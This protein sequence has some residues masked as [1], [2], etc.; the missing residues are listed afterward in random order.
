MQLP[1]RQVHPNAPPTR[2]RHEAGEVSC[3][4]FVLLRSDASNADEKRLL[5]ERQVQ[6][7]TRQ[8]ETFARLSHAAARGA[9]GPV[10]V[11]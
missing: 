11:R 7:P 9:M 1:C 8:D 2:V 6:Y 4:A 10:Q 5:L 3:A